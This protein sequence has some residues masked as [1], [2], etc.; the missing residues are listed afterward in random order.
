[1]KIMKL[2]FPIFPSIIATGDIKTG[3]KTVL[4]YLIKSLNK[5][6]EALRERRCLPGQAKGFPDHS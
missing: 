2:T 4:Q 1:M 3:H 6:R 5:A